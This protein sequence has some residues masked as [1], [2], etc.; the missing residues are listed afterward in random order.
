[1]ANN[2]NSNP[3]LLDT[4]FVSWRALQT[5][6]VG[7]L[8]SNAQQN[9][10][11]VVRQPGIRPTKILLESNGTTVAGTVSITDPIDSRILWFT[12]VIVTAGAAGTPIDE[13][14]FAEHFPTWKDFSVTGLTATVTKLYIWY[15]I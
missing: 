7:N 13:D 12:N 5:L 10:G 14:D 9:S 4:D 6:N 8:P 15:R 2:Y 1:M 11:A 3:L